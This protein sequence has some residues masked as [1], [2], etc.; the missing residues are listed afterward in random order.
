MQRTE[1]SVATMGSGKT[2][3]SKED[4]R[5]ERCQNSRQQRLVDRPDKPK[6][7]EEG[8]K[9]GV[10]RS[11]T[12]GWEKGTED[13]VQTRKFREG[14]DKQESTVDR[15]GLRTHQVRCKFGSREPERS[16]LVL[17]GKGPVN[18]QRVKG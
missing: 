15:K 13:M 4:N 17:G 10:R 1:Q 14:E 12:P 16:D 8:G 5:G 6:K 9:D 7:S 3:V 11:P 18:S 2:T